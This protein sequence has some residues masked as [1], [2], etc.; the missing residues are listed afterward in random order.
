MDAECKVSVIIPV[1][2]AAPYLDD[3]LKSIF[4]QTLQ[5]IE[6]ICVDDGSTDDSLK[7]LNQYAG[8]NKIK[9]ITQEHRGVSAARNAGIEAACGEYLYF[10]DSDDTIKP[11]AL[12]KMEAR[13]TRDE[14]DIVHCNGRTWTDSGSFRDTVMEQNVLMKRL[15]LY[16]GTYTGGELMTLMYGNHEY[17]MTPWLQLYRRDFI[18]KNNLS[19]YEGIIHED[20][21]FSFVSMLSAKRCGY[22]ED[23][24]YNKHIRPD[25]ITTREISFEH[26]YG[27]FICH[28]QMKEFLVQ[29]GREG[30]NPAAEAIMYSV[31]AEARRNYAKLGS[32]E[33]YKYYGLPYDLQV[34]F[35]TAIVD[36]VENTGNFYG[37]ESQSEQNSRISELSSGG[38]REPVAQDSTQTPDDQTGNN[39]IKRW[40]LNQYRFLRKIFHRI[41]P[42]TRHNVA[43][44]YQHLT[45][46]LQVQTQMLGHLMSMD[47]H[48]RESINR[49][50][51][52]REKLE[53]EIRN[54]Q[55]NI[56]PLL[57]RIER[58]EKNDPAPLL[59]RLESAGMIPAELM[60]EA[61][62][63][64][65][66]E[67]VLKYLPKGGIAAEV[68]VAYGD[69]SEIII[70]MLKPEHFYAIDLFQMGDIWG[71]NDFAESGLDQEAWYLRR[72]Q[73]KIPNEITIC[74]GLSWEMLEAFEDDFF[75]YVY[76]DA[77]HFY[78]DVK[79]DIAAAEKKVKHGG[80]I[81]FNDYAFW[82]PFY[83][84][85]F[86]VIPAVN[87]FVQRTGSKVLFF[88]L[89]KH[90]F[91][92][93]VIRLS[94][95]GKDE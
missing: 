16:K 63:M 12:Q 34:Q 35:R 23:V 10:M 85:Y 41:L 84:S 74:K 31:L 9:L 80:I 22:I 89:E 39:L 36:F 20:N 32:N 8:E 79:K 50:N 56:E 29:S 52:Q 77:S 95:R 3:C 19:F 57:R 2:N 93:I 48:T 58:N 66:R 13:A 25:S 5:D 42:S 86:G 72:F 51:E 94:K 88:C 6:I 49:S 65:S 78:E 18:R 62:L 43:W 17:W 14:L 64:P 1:Y 83:S 76:I 21:L 30:K 7:I 67:E 44:S 75:D 81:Q 28:L 15:H 40:F 59:L 69:F 61:L 11:E 47:Y 54:N 26:V 27:Y 73:G 45:A 87:E 24:L 90:G 70:S 33:K 91:N 37:N 68:G 92:D 46:Q 71:R 53:L 82:D 60:K 4:D 38:I 55:I